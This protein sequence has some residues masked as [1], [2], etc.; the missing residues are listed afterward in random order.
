[1][2]R[3][4]V[5]MGKLSSANGARALSSADTSVKVVLGAA[6]GEGVQVWYNKGSQR[7]QTVSARDGHREDYTYGSEGYLEA[8]YSNASAGAQGAKL[9]ERVNDRLGRT[10]TYTE[11]NGSGGVSYQRTTAYTND[12]RQR[13]QSGTDGAITYNYYNARLASGADSLAGI[14]S[15]G[16]GELAMVETV[17]NGVTTRNYT[18]YDYWDDAKQKNQT[19]SGYVE[20]QLST[21]WRPGVSKFEYDVNGHLS[22]AVDAGVDGA[23][24]TTDDVKFEYISNAQGLVLRREQ[25]K[26]QKIGMMHRYLYLNGAMVGDVGNDGDAHLDYAQ[27]LG[28]ASQNREQMYKNWQPV[29]SADFDQNYQPINRSYPAATGSSYTVKS[30]DTLYAIAGAVWGDVSMWYLIADANGLSAETTLVAGQTLTIP[31]KIA[32]IHNNSSTMRPYDAGRIIGDVSPTLPDMPPPAPPPKAGGCGVIGMIIVVIIAVVVTIYAGPVIG[33]AILT[34]GGGTAATATAVAVGGSISV[35]AAA[36]MGAMAGAALGSIA[37]QLA[38]MAMGMQDK[39]NWRAVGTSALTAMIPGGN[40]WG[41]EGVATTMASA[42]IRNVAGQG[43]A[44]AMG[45]QK[46]FSWASVAVSAIS[47]PMMSKVKLEIGKTEFAKNNLNMGMFAQNTAAAVVSATVKM[48]VTGGRISWGAVAGDAISGYLSNRVAYDSPDAVRERAR[49]G[50]VAP[51]N[52]K[53]PANSSGNA[54]SSG[55]AESLLTS[56]SSPNSASHPADGV[57]VDLSQLPRLEIP[58]LDPM[59]ISLSAEILADGSVRGRDGQVRRPGGYVAYPEAKSGGLG[60]PNGKDDGIARYA[61]GTPVALTGNGKGYIGRLREFETPLFAA[62]FEMDNRKMG[63]AFDGV[64]NLYNVMYNVDGT[65]GGVF[66]PT[67]G[68]AKDFDTVY[69]STFSPRGRLELEKFSCQEYTQLCKEAAQHDF[70][71]NPSAQTSA[72]LAQVNAPSATAKAALML[73]LAGITAGFGTA[74]LLPALGFGYTGAVGSSFISDGMFQVGNL[75]LG[76]Q[77]SWNYW[78]SAASIVLP[79]AVQ[80]GMNRWAARAERLAVAGAGHADDVPL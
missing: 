40:Y 29:S 77:D 46:S 62:G 10:T 34:A 8:T 51:A 7:I 30:G 69:A 44:M 17:N 64:K 66:D 23:V 6:G 55:A 2:N 70:D 80:L 1:M 35:G 68:Q 43:I 75:A 11:Y 65:I 5:T 14:S 53:I 16:V 31:N 76:N 48:V 27:S 32:N 73:P 42:A 49:L 37:S 47:A 57:A 18:A 22:R 19:L 56:E 24:G 67:K 59:E 21:A 60:G 13:S 78:E 54:L 9:S 20:H 25:Y 33:N 63:L 52:G 61:D 3:F 28:K 39:F 15:S 41:G 36:T 72:R 71:L 79:G 4:T 45:E 26:G 12:G 74:Y 50:R 38:G 58:E